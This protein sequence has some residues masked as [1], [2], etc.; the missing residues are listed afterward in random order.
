MNV[1]LG[2]TISEFLFATFLD[3][4]QHRE[5]IQ[6]KKIVHATWIRQA[7]VSW[8]FMVLRWS[9]SVQASYLQTEGRGKNCRISCV[10]SV[11]CIARHTSNPQ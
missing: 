10:V 4:I 1:A 8:I 11:R 3:V 9:V 5:V 6:H 7:E 2:L